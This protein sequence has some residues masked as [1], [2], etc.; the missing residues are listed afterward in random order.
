MKKS[1][2]ILLYIFAGIAV[3]VVL[4]IAANNYAE[5]RIK[6]AIEKNLQQAEISYSKINVSLLSRKAAA[7]QPHLEMQNKEIDAARLSLDDIGVFDYLFGDKIVI[8]ELKLEKPLVKLL[9]KKGRDSSAKPSKKGFKKEILIKEFRVEN[10]SFTLSKKDSSA[11]KLFARLPLISFSG[12]KIDSSSVKKQIPFTYKKYKLRADSL[13]IN[14]N[15]E[16]DI[17]IGNVQID[18]GEVQVKDFRIRPKYSKPEFQKHIPYE[19][20]RVELKIDSIG[21]SDLQ[22]KMT[23]DTLEF[24]NPMT[25]ISNAEL[26]LYRDKRQPDFP[27]T[28]PL[29]SK[30]LRQLPV[31][32]KFDTL[33]LRNVY[34]RYEQMVKGERGPGM[35][36]FSNLNATIYNLTNVDLGRKDYPLTQVDARADFMREAPVVIDWNFNV[37]NPADYFTISGNMGQLSGDGINSFMSPAMGVKAQGSIEDLDFDFSGNNEKATGETSLQYH[38]FKVVVLKDNG[39]KKS[40]LLSALANLIVDN[41]TANEKQQHK[42]ISV[43]RDEHKSFWNYFWLCIRAGALKSFLKF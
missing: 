36:D 18:D 35:L 37:S 38:D 9:S 34:I 17:L 22:W 42:N 24:D 33:K 32:L 16:H 12:V 29:Y 25:R 28:K 20:D 6:K 4:L 15:S 40:G 14:M 39:K 1:K 21:L 3:L 41:K 11:H 2:K 5:Y 10:G 23:N 13:F 27:G 19:K 7:V 26:K 43:T 30:M 31:K 8:G